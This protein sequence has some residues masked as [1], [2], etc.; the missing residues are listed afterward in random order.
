MARR[1]IGMKALRQMIELHEKTQFSNRQ[2]AAATGVS[3]PAVADY[4]A[5]YD[6]SGLSWDEFSSLT[7][8]EV[9][10]RLT[11]P[12]AIVDERLAAAL[13][14]FPYMLKELSRVGMTREILW[15]EYRAKHSDGFQYSQFC[16]HFR[17]DTQRGLQRTMVTLS[18]L[19]LLSIYKI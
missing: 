19:L 3:R 12:K 11:R 10:E 7:D 2:I 13:D 16:T 17:V 4:V 18:Y 9:V 5:A 8:T 6:R 15:R 14:F 1:R